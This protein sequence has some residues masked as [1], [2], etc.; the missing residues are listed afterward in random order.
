[1]VETLTDFESIL[2]AITDGVVVVDAHGIV[3]YANQSAERIFE[4]GRLLGREL[5][6]PLHDGEAH[7]DINLIR[8]DGVGWAE[9]RSAPITWM[10][11]R[12]WVIGIRDI[13]ERK[14]IELREHEVASRIE[15]AMLGTIDVVSRMMDL[16]DPYTSGHERRVGE[17]AAAIAAEMGLDADTQRGLRVAGNLHDVGKI[18]VPAEIL[19][20][21]GKLSALEF[22]M[23]KGHAEL[24]YQ[25]LKDIDFPWPVAEVAYQHHERIDGSGYPRGL[26]GD[27]ILIDARIMAVADVVEAMSSH[28]P[29]RE[30]MG[31]DKAVADIER[32]RGTIYD[33]K[34]ADA[35]VRLF[36]DKGYSIPA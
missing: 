12:A 18:T 14:Q 24:G 2:A 13:T 21:P 8:P 26:K 27:A 11:Q 4:R 31:I 7:Q 3:L 5:A 9:L 33:A 6:I 17:V 28:R 22:E 29:Y 32:G 36:R 15:H 25:V 16:R 1:M 19:S 10:N 30:G 20:K 35:C 23:I 34:V